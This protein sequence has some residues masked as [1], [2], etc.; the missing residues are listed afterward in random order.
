MIDFMPAATVADRERFRCIGLAADPRC[1]AQAREEFARWL[2][3]FFDTDELRMNDM[4]LAVN[5][6]LANVAEFAYVL[7][8]RP[9][10]MDVQATYSAGDRR[11]TATVADHGVWQ[12]PASARARNRGRGVALMRVLTDR[13]IIETGPDGT[14]V[15]L[16]WNGVCQS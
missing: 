10:T 5:E 2:Q 13:T 9:G 3:R 7:A 12:M 15:Q 8:D 4:V 6:A 1:A 11:L 14:R 16:E